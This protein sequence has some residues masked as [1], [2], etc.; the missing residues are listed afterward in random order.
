[1]RGG[2]SVIFTQSVFRLFLLHKSQELIIPPIYCKRVR[3]YKMETKE[4]LGFPKG[5]RVMTSFCF[6]CP[7]V[8]P[9]RYTP[10]QDP[11]PLYPTIPTLTPSSTQRNHFALFQPGTGLWDPG[12]LSPDH[13]QG[14]GEGR[15]ALT[16]SPPLFPGCCWGKFMTLSGLGTVPTLKRKKKERKK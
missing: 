8:P 12:G 5:G 4:A 11:S 1:M 6:F 3:L 9:P 15:R 13:P 2:G 7:Q 16:G 10:S 14:L